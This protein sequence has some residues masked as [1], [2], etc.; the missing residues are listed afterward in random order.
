MRS[1]DAQH[2][3]ANQVLATLTTQDAG[4]GSVREP[5]DVVLLDHDALD[6]A[7]HERSI[8]GFIL[9]RSLIQAC[10]GNRDGHLGGDLVGDLELLGRILACGSAEAH[11]AY[12]LTPR[13]H[14][15]HHVRLNPGREQSV[16]LSASGERPDVDHLPLAASQGLDIAHERHRKANTRPEMHAPTAGGCQPLDLAGFQVKEVDDRPR[17]AEQI[18]QSPK[19]R[20]GNRLG[21][22]CRNDPAVNLMEDLEPLGGSLEGPLRPTPGCRGTMPRLHEHAD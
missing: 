7:L 4:H 14:R 21:S 11:R 8:T 16:H 5:H 3:S 18:L 17:N 2:V 19:G 6:R 13:N 1:R 22:L 15:H 20:G 10:L 12:E 9:C